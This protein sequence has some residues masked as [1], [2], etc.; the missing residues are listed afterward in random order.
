MHLLPYVFVSSFYDTEAVEFCKS[1]LEK[2]DKLFQLEFR[3]GLL[4]IFSVLIP[5]R[6]T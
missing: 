5:I 6:T 2:E 4:I 1:L 3:F